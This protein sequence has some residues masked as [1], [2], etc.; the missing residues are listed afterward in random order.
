MIPPGAPPRRAVLSVAGALGVL[1]PLVVWWIA[2]ALTGVSV[3]LPPPQDV[4]VVT[5]HELLRPDFLLQVGATVLRGL[6]A[7]AVATVLGIPL[8]LAAGRNAVVY[9][10]TRPFILAVRAIP[11]ISVILVAVIWFSSGT[12]PVFTAVLMAL[13]I[14]V[15]AARTAVSA[16][17]PRLVEM[18]HVH[19]WG[20]GMRLRHLWWPGA[21]YGTLGGVR[22]AAGI[23]WKVTV[24]AEVLSS[25]AVGIGAQM[26]EARL[27]LET[28]RI[29]AWTI[30]LIFVA[31]V[32]DGLLRRAQERSEPTRRSQGSSRAG[33]TAAI[34]A[35]RGV[36]SSSSVTQA[37][38]STIGAARGAGS[39]RAAAVGAPVGGE[40]ASGE[41][42][43]AAPSEGRVATLRLEQV[44]F[45]WDETPLMSNLSVE[46]S[47]D[48]VTA[49]V[50]PSG[51]G[52]TTL[53]T[54]CAGAI[55]PGGGRVVAQPTG[56]TPP[57][58][59]MVFQEPRLLPWRSARENVALAGAAANPAAEADATLDRVGLAGIGDAYPHE[60]S[61]G[62]Q[63]RVAVARAMSRS[64]E[65]LLVD[66]PLSG[67]DPQHRADLVEELKTVIRRHQALTVVASHDL[68]FVLAIADRIVVLSGPPVTIAADRPRPAGGWPAGTAAEIA[69]MVAEVRITNV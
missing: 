39:G 14:V 5:F 11:F 12:V 30:V 54:L 61:G 17:D 35:A 23:A 37:T 31:G 27:F 43:V 53:L 59:G 26:G 55:T 40:D 1:L 57:R 69:S 65:I 49:V 21:L 10:L 52:K 4:I 41:G 7:I 38:P 42:G 66:E 15:D 50:G 22:S 62:M 13:P 29:L 28:E 60:L 6:G 58:V 16:V 67:V 25:P 24:A 46:F 63:Q 51:I 33:D 47:R 44:S 2:A 36:G 20:G 3:A 32:S 68:E 56:E 8:G 45:A 34:G 48:R 18:T 64:P 9:A 19:R